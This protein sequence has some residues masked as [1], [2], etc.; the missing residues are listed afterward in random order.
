VDVAL[1]V[2]SGSVALSV[3][4]ALVTCVSAGGHWLRHRPPALDFVLEN[5]IKFQKLPKEAQA[6]E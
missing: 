4:V 1:V 3:R 6:N 2:V 5:M